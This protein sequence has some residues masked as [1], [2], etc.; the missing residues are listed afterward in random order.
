MSADAERL[1]TGE[2]KDNK[3]GKVRQEVPDV[4]YDQ[5]LA[6]LQAAGWDSNTAVKNIKLEKLIRYIL[7]IKTG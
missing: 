7:Y 3:I 6:A 2:F 4:E 1:M 5:C